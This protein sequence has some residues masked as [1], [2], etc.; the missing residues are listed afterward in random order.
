MLT[1]RRR[2]NPYIAHGAERLGVM[3]QQAEGSSPSV[4]AGRSCRK[5]GK[6]I[7]NKAVVKGIQKNLQRRKFCLECSPFGAHNTKVDDPSRPSYRKADYRLIPIE[8]RRRYAKRASQRGKERRARLLKMSGGACCKCGYD[9]C[10]AA[11]DF[12][13][14]KESNKLFQ[15][16][17]SNLWSK[18][19]ET[20]LSEWRKCDLLCS[21]CHRE[22]HYTKAG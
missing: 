10:T 8:I 20:I 14:R 5:C 16:S 1:D 15:L 12:H 7:P 3:I 9:R 11:L 21:N 17:I 13:H 22:L 2:T 19:W 4:R 18:A 6:R